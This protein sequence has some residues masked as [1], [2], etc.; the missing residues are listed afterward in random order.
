[1]LQLAPNPAVR[2]F[3][4]KRIVK[5]NTILAR[6]NQAYTK[7]ILIHELIHLKVHNHQNDFYH[8]IDKLIPNYRVYKSELR[9]LAGKYVI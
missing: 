4:Q 3:R 8:Y 2:Q 9:K 6:F 7:I 5:L 1:M